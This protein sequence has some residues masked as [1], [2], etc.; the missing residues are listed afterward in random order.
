[1][2]R[3]LLSCSARYVLC[4]R[5]AFFGG[6]EQ[7]I[8]PPK[9]QVEA[10]VREEHCE[11]GSGFG[12][13]DDELKS[14]NYGVLFTPKVEY[15]FAADKAEFDKQFGEKYLKQGSTTN[16]D[17]GRWGLDAGV[18]PETKESVLQTSSVLLQSMVLV[19]IK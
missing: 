4:C 1:M 12:A 13:S 6:L 2:C 3:S 16:G 11:V 10:A 19:R 9:I 14:N 17:V 18:H 8:G 7:L 5:N 15:L